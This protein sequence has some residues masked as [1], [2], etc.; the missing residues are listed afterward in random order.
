[1]LSNNQTLIDT[2]LWTG[3]SESVRWE[4]YHSATIPEPSKCTAAFCVAITQGD[5]IVL[6]REERGWG[7]IGGHIEA[8]ESIEQALVRECLEEGGFIVE[9]PILFGYKKI[10]ATKPV[11]HPTP[12]MAYPFPISYV[13]YYYAA[14]NKEL[15]TPTEQEVL[16]VK[17]F[18]ID[19]INRLDISD[20]SVIRLGWETYQSSTRA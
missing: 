5:R 1:M 10:I 11:S 16:E 2:G 14:N 20:N 13:A 6:E 8:G 12:G 19:E 17:T 4:L 9:D 3:D 15:S 18:T 7:T